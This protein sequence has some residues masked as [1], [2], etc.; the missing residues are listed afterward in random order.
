M[1]SAPQNPQGLLQLL[2][3]VDTTR[4]PRRNSLQFRFTNM[5]ATAG[6]ISPIEMEQI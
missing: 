2:G 1:W 3:Y 5:T 6:I 4:I